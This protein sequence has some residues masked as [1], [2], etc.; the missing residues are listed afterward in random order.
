MK[1][2]QHFWIWSLIVLMCSWRRHRIFRHTKSYKSW[3]ALEH[4]KSQIW[5]REVKSHFLQHHYQ[6]SLEEDIPYHKVTDVMNVTTYIRY[7]TIKY[8]IFKWFIANQCFIYGIKSN[9]ICTPKCYRQNPVHQYMMLSRWY[10]LSTWLLKQY[11]EQFLK[12][13]GQWKFIW[14]RK[15]WK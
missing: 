11:E 5:N 4:I 10:I 15:W 8:S 13:N 1:G 12:I 3:Y 14:R 7:V 2:S 6:Q 9:F